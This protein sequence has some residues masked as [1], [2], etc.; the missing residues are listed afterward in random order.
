[1]KPHAP[2]STRQLHWLRRWGIFERQRTGFKMPWTYAA[3]LP[4]LRSPLDPGNFLRTN[5]FQKR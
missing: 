4:L 2:I 1:W 3:F 5:C